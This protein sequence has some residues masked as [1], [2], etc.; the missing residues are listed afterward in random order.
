MQP[1]DDKGGWA[2]L[3]RALPRNSCRL[4]RRSSRPTFVVLLFLPGLHHFLG[5]PAHLAELARPSPGR[6]KWAKWT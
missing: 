1:V 2:Y 3:R 6:P 4:D 5:W